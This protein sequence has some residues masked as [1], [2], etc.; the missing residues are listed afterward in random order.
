MMHAIKEF[1]KNYITSLN[2]LIITRKQLNMYNLLAVLGVTV[3][4]NTNKII[5]FYICRLWN[6]NRRERE[7]GIENTENFI[8]FLKL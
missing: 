1:I 8:Y 3:K 5:V 6:I 4:I 2:L 7:G